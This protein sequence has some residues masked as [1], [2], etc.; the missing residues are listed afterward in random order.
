MRRTLGGITAFLAF[1][2][3]LLVLPV[4]AAP[5]PEPEPVETSTEQ[6]DMGSVDEPAPEAEVQD[7]TTEPV[8][9]V[10]P[11]EPALTVSQTD[12]A[13]FSLVGVTWAYDPAV[14]DTVVQ[15]RAQADDGSWGDWT[16]VV[17]EDADQ[18]AGTDSGA[19]QRGGTAP[20]WTG[21]STGVEAELVT[22]SGAQPTDVTLDLVD[23]GTSDADGALSTPDIQDTADAAMAMPDVYSRAQWGADENIRTWDPEYAPTIKAATV[24]HTADTNNYTADQVPAMMRSIYRYHTVSRGWGDIGYNVIVDKYGRLWEGRFGG[25]ASTVIGAHAGGFNTGTFGVSML[26]NYDTAPTTPAMIT[27]VEAIIA[28]KFDLYGVDANGTV[29]LTSAGGGTSRYAAGT[30][31]TLPT[32]FGHR[33]VGSTT[34]PGQYGYAKLGEIRAVV[35]GGAANNAFV[36]ALY[37]DMMVRDA[38]DVG[39]AG[40]ASALTTG[41]WSR[42]N[43]SGGFATSSEYRTLRITQA[44]DQVF[45]RAP[46]AGGLT[47]WRVA[48]GNGSL[49]LD[50]L[51]PMLMAS[52]EFYNRGGSTDASFVD[53]IYRAALGR[54][55]TDSEV[56]FWGPLRARHGSAAVISS[57]WG[58]AESAMRRVDQ[59][60]QYYLGRASGRSEQEFWLPVVMG[61]GD[62]QLREE[63]IISQEYLLRSTERYP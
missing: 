29:L 37:A 38:D 12:T 46:D 54:A 17:V 13:E 28:W 22:R 1:S 5:A 40:W 35:G 44:Y 61:R 58:S 50:N 57:V 27:A 42:R 53:N 10:S 63:V 33:D 56:A 51:R 21:P 49:S 43:V 36:R 11:T 30:R 8:G 23:P 52:P 16:A 31:V 24:H 9:G 15:V 4:Y 59:A 39:L 45:G 60:Y 14:T 19:A 55:A 41:G 25:L 62:E 3:T 6:V 18:N 7:G 48:L 20:L 2:G 34:C 32:I 26:G 47:T